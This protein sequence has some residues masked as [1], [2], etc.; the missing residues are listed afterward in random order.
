[1]ACDMLGIE[2]CLSL[3]TK[4][5]LQPESFLYF[6]KGFRQYPKHEKIKGKARRNTEGQRLEEPGKLAEL[7]TPESAVVWR[8][9]LGVAA[10]CPRLFP[11]H[12]AHVPH[13]SCFLRDDAGRIF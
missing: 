3:S 2:C 1:M 12:A 7:V 8:V 6:T 9:S 5:S 4:F 13:A 10:A 11:S